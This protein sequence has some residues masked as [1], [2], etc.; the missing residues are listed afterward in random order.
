MGTIK[1]LT[2]MRTNQTP[3]G[4]HYYIFKFYEDM[5]KKMG[6]DL[7][8]VSPGNKDTYEAL[9][10]ICDGLLLTGGLDVDATFYGEENHPTN[11]IEMNAIDQLDL[12]LIHLFHSLNKP[13]IGI[14]RGHQILN[15]AFGGTLIQD[16]KS[17]YETSICHQQTTVEGYTHAIKVLEDSTMAKYVKDGSMVNSFH[18]QNIKDVAKGFKV[19]AL[20]EDGLVEAIENGNMMSVQWHPEKYNDDTQLKIVEMFKSLF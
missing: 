12:D 19:M 14:C 5:F 16:I 11:N 4:T 7:I 8:L 1:L 13:I 2:T 15:V 20:S 3:R 6:A 9:A 18:H 17:Q 10:S